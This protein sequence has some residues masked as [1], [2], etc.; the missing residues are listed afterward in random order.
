MLWVERITVCIL[1]K[2]RDDIMESG[3]IVGMASLNCN[4]MHE[5]SCIFQ[6]F[7][8]YI[9]NFPIMCH[10]FLS[11]WGHFYFLFLISID[12]TKRNIL[13]CFPLVFNEDRYCISHSIMVMAT[14]RIFDSSVLINLK[15]H[16]PSLLS[17]I[18]DLSLF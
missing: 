18:K 9:S 6:D 3:Y 12:Y 2:T 15:Y 13:I 7:L 8:R 1:L 10:F 14:P 16:F 4:I 5:C 17:M 11:W